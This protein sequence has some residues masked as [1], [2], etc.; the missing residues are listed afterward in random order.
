MVHHWWVY[1]RKSSSGQPH[2]KSM[3]SFVDLVPKPGTG[4]YSL[5]AALP[6]WTLACSRTHTGSSALSLPIKLSIIFNTT[7]QRVVSC[8]P[9]TANQF[10]P[11]QELTVNFSTFQWAAI[12]LIRQGLNSN[13]GKG[14][15]PFPPLSN[16]IFSWEI[17][18]IPR[19]SSR[20][21]FTFL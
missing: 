18:L 15:S 7:T 21:T 1:I 17:S 4:D 8:Y 19:I 20:V 2:T 12:Q 11:R 10:W 16:F 5:D 3:Q 14:T 13:P 9:A 6:I